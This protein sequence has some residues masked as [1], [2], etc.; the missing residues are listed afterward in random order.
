MSRTIFRIALLLRDTLP[1]NP[2]HVAECLSLLNELTCQLSDSS[3]SFLI[4]LWTVLCTYASVVSHKHA[5]RRIRNINS[6]LAGTDPA[7][8]PHR[9]R[10]SILFCFVVTAVVSV[11]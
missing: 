7:S 11:T 3:S 5:D 10:A 6:I 2:C 1:I 4:V 9:E 8:L